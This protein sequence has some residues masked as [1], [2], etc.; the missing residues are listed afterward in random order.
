MTRYGCSRMTVSKA[1]SELTQADLIERRRRAGTFVRRPK[2]LSAVLQIADIRAEIT[3]LGRRYG[4]EL[5]QCS[6]RAA[7][8]ADRA[9]LGVRKTGKVIAIAC[10]HS[11][12]DV[13]FAIEDRLI[14]LDAVP[15]ALT[16]D[17]RRHHLSHRS[18]NLDIRQWQIPGHLV[19]QKHSN[20]LEE[21]AE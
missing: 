18:F 8:A 7:N 10:R 15:E 16:G 6:R 11:A 9:R 17:A 13:P 20:L 5:I 4:Y 3:A 1:L 19:T 12:D 21:F 14:D 2:F